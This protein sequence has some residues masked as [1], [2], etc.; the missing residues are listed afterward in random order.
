MRGGT[1]P[2]IKKITPSWAGAAYRKCRPQKKTDATSICNPAGTNTRRP[3][4]FFCFFALISRGSA[5]C[6][7]RRWLFHALERE[8]LLTMVPGCRTRTIDSTI[9][10]PVGETLDPRYICIPYASEFHPPPHH[11]FGLEAFARGFPPGV[12][13]KKKDP[14]GSRGF[15][16]GVDRF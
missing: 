10:H 16:P 15:P 11:L 14:P 7:S 13:E 9:L 1:Q 2:R 4:S 6:T 12:N 8:R 5:P 3:Q